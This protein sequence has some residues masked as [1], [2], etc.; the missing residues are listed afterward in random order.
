MPLPGKA[1]PRTSHRQFIEF[2]V[3]IP[4][5]EPHDGQ[6]AFSSLRSS[7]SSILPALNAPTASNAVLRSRYLSL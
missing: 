1:I 2:A 7:S 3:N 6:A 4:E 5:H